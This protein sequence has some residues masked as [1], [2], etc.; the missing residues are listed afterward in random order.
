MV[1]YQTM[2]EDLRRYNNLG[3]PKYFF[4]LFNTLRRNQEIVYTMSDVDKLFYNREIDNRSVFDGCVKLAIKINFLFHVDNLL[5]LNEAVIESLNDID[6]MK[7]VFIKHLFEVF[8]EDDNF[9]RIFFPEFL[10]Y[11][12]IHK[13]L[14]IS[15]QAFGLKYYNLKQLLLDFGVIKIHPIIEF[16]SYLINNSYKNLIDK[17]I[18]PEVKQKRISVEDFWNSMEQK[19]I[20]G[21]EAE[22]FVLEFESIRLNRKKKIDWIAQYVVNEGYDIASYNYEHDEIPNRFIEVKSY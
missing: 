19:Q 21:V 2:L 16:K 15:N 20:F 17:I 6:Q 1:Y 4:E 11:D 14:Q 9:C 13:S 10:S 5:T 18:V 22:K 7:R 12:V 8:V 3:T